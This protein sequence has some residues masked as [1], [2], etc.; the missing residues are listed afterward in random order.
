M[1]LR[2][3]PLE[4]LV[5][6]MKKEPDWSV[7]MSACPLETTLDLNAMRESELVCGVPRSVKRPSLSEVDGLSLRS[8]GSKW[9][10]LVASRCGTSRRENSCGWLLLS[11]GWLGVCC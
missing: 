7:K 5:S 3:V 6:L 8:M 9:S 10:D 4:L 2:K 1:W 11:F